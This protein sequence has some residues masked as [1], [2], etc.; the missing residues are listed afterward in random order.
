MCV[1]KFVIAPIGWIVR[2]RLYANT[3]AVETCSFVVRSTVDMRLGPSTISRPLESERRRRR[4]LTALA[5]AVEA[6]AIL[7]Q[8]KHGRRERARRDGTRR[9]DRALEKCCPCRRGG[10]GCLIAG[11]DRADAREVG[12]TAGEF[13]RAPLGVWQVAIE[14]LSANGL[15]GPVD[16]LVI[17]GEWGEG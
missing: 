2:L 14:G 8:V 12:A 3:E 7:R 9:L 11:R 5:L 10:W 6:G 13:E 1:R 15:D 4:D 16:V 17:K